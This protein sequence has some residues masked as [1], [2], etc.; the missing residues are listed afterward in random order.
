MNK[1][2]LI[3]LGVIAGVA[4]FI[5]L[6]CLGN[7][8]AT[9]IEAPELVTSAEELPIV[10][11]EADFSVSQTIQTEDWG[12]DAATE[13]FLKKS[14]ADPDY[15]W[16][17]PIKFYGK[18]ITLE[19]QPLGGV[20][21]EYGWTALTG[22]ERRTV[23]SDANGLF[24]L[25]DVRGKTMTM[26]LVKEGYDWFSSRTQRQFEYAEPYAPNY[27]VANPDEPL[28]YYMQKRPEAEPLHAW[29]TRRGV[30]H[31]N[32]T[33]AYYNYVTGRFSREPS[34]NCIR[35][36]L[37]IDPADEQNTEPYNWTVILSGSGYDF[38]QTDD[39]VSS[40]APEDGYSELAEFGKSA[41]D[42]TWYDARTYQVFFKNKSGKHGYLW[43]SPRVSKESQKVK[44]TLDSYFNPSGSRVLVFSSKKRIR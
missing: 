1:N 41:D 16:K 39:Y 20:A 23:E 37:Q 33:P 24:D 9:L 22:Y 34:E 7:G 43:L 35:M 36:E 11:D 17:Q 4:T 26:K 10:V 6:L 2:T 3:A 25:T 8:K 42:K 28:I 31:A 19:G 32:E 30:I 40:I 5:V 14:M 38:Y 29:K 13:A 21:V 27:H 12:V 44:V 18:V 15:E